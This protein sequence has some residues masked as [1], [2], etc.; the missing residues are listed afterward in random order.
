MAVFPFCADQMEAGEASAE[1]KNIYQ[2]LTQK[3]CMD[4]A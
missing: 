4:Q 2:G 1:N 3:T